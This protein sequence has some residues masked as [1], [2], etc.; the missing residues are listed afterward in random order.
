MNLE[1]LAFVSK[2]KIR[3]KV[4]GG[5]GLI[6]AI[7]VV[8]AMILLTN[9]SA[10]DGKIKGVIEDRQP[11]V[12]ASLSLAKDLNEAASQLGFYAMSKEKTHLDQ[13]ERVIT[14][15]SRQLTALKNNPVIRSSKKDRQLVATIEQQVEKFKSYKQRFVEL[16]NDD[17][18][19]LVAA[20]YASHTLNPISQQV[21]QQASA[22]IQTES[23]EESNDARKKLLIDF[24][25]YRYNWLNI[26]T[27][28][29]SYI[30]LGADV[31]YKQINDY[32]AV[33]RDILKRIQ[34]QGD[35]L[36]LD[37]EDS[38]DNI[39]KLSDQFITHVADVKKI[40]DSGKWRMDAYLVRTEVG[41]LLADIT[42]KLN[43]LVDGQ[44]KGIVQTSN[45]LLAQVKET[46]STITMLILI[47]IFIGVSAAWVI[48]R[49]ITQR[50]TVAIDA[51]H[52][53]AEGDGDLTRR[54]D[55]SGSD[56]IAQ[57]ASGFN[58]FAG[59]IQNLVGRVTGFTSQLASAASEMSAITEETSR[60]AQNQQGE[61][62]Q[63]VSAIDE[64]MISV[65]DVARN[66]SEAASSAA[67]A[68]DETIKGQKEVASTV[69]SIN[70]L[71][72][73]VE[74]AA[75]VIHKLGDDSQ[76]IGKVLDVIKGIAEQTN[77]LAL[78]AAIEA[79]RAGE[80]GRGFAVVADEV[81]TL[82]SRTQQSTQEIQHMIESL[83]A[84]S[85]DAVHAMEGSRNMAQSSVEQAARAGASLE[86]IA[87]AVNT[88]STMNIQIASAAEQQAAV[89]SGINSSIHSISKVC[90]QTADGARQTAHSGEEL[91]RLAVE[92]QSLL[93]QFRI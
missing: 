16:V 60:G 44:S 84:G 30:V 51:M 90:D 58:M 72:H 32:I 40:Y 15:V 11:T 37:E 49:M 31:T 77:L 63:V 9:L 70:A 38:V 34:A 62:E 41:P 69:N 8:V 83:Q 43:Q 22:M 21:L 50:M 13:Y 45:Q 56:E 79:A 6:L 54:L 19:N 39:A 33:T 35:L 55:D 4:W 7:L 67:H 89:S 10:V 92:L 87:G 91:A 25:A 71:A 64:L 75:T 18:K 80:Q 17:I 47:G 23:N 26:M 61:T 57:L 36:T 68:D 74:R 42:A 27:Q 1:K 59:K 24:D 52:D 73:E 14:S 85:D 53:I 93:G 20:E 29:R 28:M 78:N 46:S 66:A 48:A 86:V 5:F 82:A 12:I 2:L 65:Q 81:R 76:N 88:I 3:H